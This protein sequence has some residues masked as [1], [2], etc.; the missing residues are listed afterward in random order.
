MGACWSNQIKSIWSS[1]TVKSSSE[2]R[3]DKNWSGSSSKVSSACTIPQQP[4]RSE[5]EI[6][7]SSNLKS[8]TFIELR[9]S[10]RNFRP[11]SVLGQGGFGSVYKGWVDEHSLTATKPGSGILIAVKRLNQDGIQGHKEWLAEINYLGQLDHPNLV[12]LIGY[13]LEDEHRLLVYEFM[14]R[15]SME[16]HLFRRG[17][18]IQ[19]L[20]WGVRMKLA[21]GA[22]KGLAFLHNAKTQVIY[23]DFKTSNILLDSDYN[24][25]L[26]DFGLARDGPT[27]DRSHVSTRVMGTHGYAAPE[28]LVTGHLTAKS[29]IYSFGVVLLEIICG[30]RA[31]DKNKPSGEHNLVEWAKPYLTN[32]RRVFR[33]LDT[34]LQGQYS[35]NRVQKAAHLALHCL[36]KEPKSRPSMDEVVKRLEQLQ[37]PG[38]TPGN[39]M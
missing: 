20:S 30:R 7:Q 1:T 10:T 5:G 2:A 19:P 3:N 13:C 8:F 36:A 16:N 34:R 26:S 33:V 38:G 28:Y 6:L 31:I 32:K 4:S 9:A 14:P 25:K 15:G 27:G 39:A 35:L 23:R 18:H 11:D 21:L 12:K 37:E 22:A 17:S 29:D 24:A